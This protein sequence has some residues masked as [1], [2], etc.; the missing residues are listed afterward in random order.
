[1]KAIILTLAI[2]MFTLAITANPNAPTL[3][4]EIWYDTDGHMMMELHGSFYDI[5][6]L[7]SQLFFCNGDSMASFPPDVLFPYWGNTVVI[8]ATIEFPNLIFNPSGDT[9][10]I[11]YI[12]E[13]YGQ[14]IEFESLKWGDSFVNDINPLLPGQSFVHWRHYYFDGDV[15]Y[16]YKDE[17]P[18]PGLYPNEPIARDTVKVIITNQNGVPLPN[19]NLYSYTLYNVPFGCTDNSGT[20]IDTLMA[21]KFA[22]I[23]RHP[24]TSEIVHNQKYW[25][26]PNQTTTIPII[27]DYVAND[28]NVVPHLVY[29]GLHAY[30]TPFNSSKADFITF[31]YEGETK[32]CR[33]T[34]IRLYDTKG[35]FIQQIQMSNK[36]LTTWKPS[37]DIGSGHYFARLISGNRILDT[38]TFTI[39]K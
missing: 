6:I 38:I 37:A 36:G 12:N 2:M 16:W 28:D 7:P 10:T 27:I 18:T 23:V 4:S 21:G 13:D 8:D 26:E 32:L 35:R 34:H 22:L 24:L 1:M 14:D 25:L 11:R 19:I 15:R 33:E 20:Y 31:K 30:P 9:L 39:I 29:K 5:S 3:I 17:P